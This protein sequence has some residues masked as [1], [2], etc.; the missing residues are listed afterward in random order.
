[1]KIEIPA[2]YPLT[3]AGC[4]RHLRVAQ[5]APGVH[6]AILKL[7]GDPVLTE[8]VGKALAKLMPSDIQVLA[9]P[10]GKAQPLLH[11][12]QRE[13]GLPAVLARK[14]RKSY[15]VDPVIDSVASSITTSK[16]TFYLDALDVTEIEGRRV[17]LIDDVVSKG[18]TFD[19]M[20]YLLKRA[21]AASILEM[22][23]GT[24][25]QERPDVIKLHHFQVY[26]S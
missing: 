5:V 10:D 25:G 19:A 17:A 26:L 20:R 24:E 22:A 2:Y 3:I 23:V 13:T 1:M 16:S 12:I 15:M 21:D 14:E 4:T 11:V 6:I 18:G 9:M 7:I 8:V